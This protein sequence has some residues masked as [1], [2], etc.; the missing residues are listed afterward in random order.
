MDGQKPGSPGWGQDPDPLIFVSGDEGAPAELAAPPGNYLGYYAAIRDAV[1]GDGELPV[2][3]AQATTVMAVIEAGIRSSVEGTVVSP[4]YTDAERSA[5][6]P[7]GRRMQG[8]RSDGAEWLAAR[9]GRAEASPALLR[10]RY[11]GGQ[12]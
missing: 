7:A 8:G 12:R 3:P 5:W 1:R 9:S 4:S 6:N 2:T 11:P 10:R